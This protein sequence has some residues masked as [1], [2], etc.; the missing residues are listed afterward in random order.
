MNKNVG[1]RALQNAKLRKQGKKQ[2]EVLLPRAIAAYRL[3]Q[4]AEARM[5]CEQVVALWPEN[6]DGWH[7]FGLATLDCGEP[8]D[9][10]PILR[11]ALGLNP[12]SPDAQ[13]NLGVA[14]FEIKDFEAAC[15]CY[16]RAITLRTD[17]P[18]AHNNLGNALVKLRR[19]ADALEAY[20]R[21]ITLAPNY[22]DAYYNR[23]MV[24]LLLGRLEDALTNVDQA[25]VLRS[26]YPEALSG[27]GM[28]LYM[29]RR[30][31]EALADLRAALVL[32]PDFADA[33]VN[34]ARIQFEL[35]DLDACRANIDAALALTPNLNAAWLE[36]AQL[37]ILTNSIADAIE[38]CEH[39][40]RLDPNS[41]KALV[42]L[43]SCYQ[44]R[45]N[46]EAAVE[47]Y[48]RALAIQPDD[49]GAIHKKI[50]ALDFVSSA[51]AEIQQA[52]RKYWWQQIGS[53]LP[54][55]AHPQ[56]DPA[57]DDRRLLIGYVS[58]DFRNHSAAY[59]F[60][61]VLRNRDR[62]RFGVVCYSSS[63]QQDDFTETFRSIADQFVDVSQLSDELL[64]ARIKADE[65]D[66]LVDLSG[67]SAGN[68]MGVFA[69]KPAP[70]QVT[71]WG[72]ATGTGL[73]TMDYL[74]SDPVTCP[75]EHRP[76]FAEKIHDLPAL[77]TLEPPPAGLVSRASPM[78]TR[79]HVTFGI[80]N[81][82]DKISDGFMARLTE[83]L[84]SLPDSRLVIKNGALD[85]R[86]LKGELID[87]FVLRGVSA[88]RI[89]CVGGTTRE[90]HLRAFEDIDISLD[91]FP[92][93]GGVSTWESLQMGVPVLALLGSGAA[94]RAA[95][96]IV[97]SLGMHEWVAETEDRYV[98]TAL[99]FAVAPTS[100][101]ALRA[102]LP[103][104]ILDSASGN[105]RTYARHVEDAFRTFWRARP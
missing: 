39:A 30:F 38:S 102:A 50:F 26:R 49:E 62:D 18:T 41:E 20:N 71:A 33:M 63:L 9:A 56:R 32:R 68:R 53:K 83:I 74:F 101:Q 100:V 24:L 19:R 76:F 17:Y 84:G 28:V 67:H 25:L 86:L 98:A 48:D 73:P 40:L 72:H 95:A 2:A 60:L 96:A 82:I 11:K 80:F 31:D 22:A 4:F 105:G 3:G 90:D 29:L 79:G 81:R 77:I 87:R 5:I 75:A 99:K 8:A 15:T 55:F 51:D 46:A 10:V 35:H 58:S 7:L 21:A 61:P 104:M 64:A 12:R 23:A 44:K 6:F 66:V 85:D 103:Q 91:P 70:V 69:R 93:N 42:V 1:L 57:D 52:A 36:K 14:L 65:V 59:T 89:T 54:R 37:C 13:S 88:D 94:S 43:G 27:R 16:R 97:T 47:M 34:M 92:Q 78:L 45:G